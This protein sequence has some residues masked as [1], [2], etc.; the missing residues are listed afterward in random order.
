M[1]VLV[2]REQGAVV[3]LDKQAVL[4]LLAVVLMVALVAVLAKAAA[5]KAAAAVEAHRNLQKY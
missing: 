2:L 4:L 1:S 5:A 3:E